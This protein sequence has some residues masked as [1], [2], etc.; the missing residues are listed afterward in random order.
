MWTAFADR[1]AEITEGK[2]EDQI[3]M[4]PGKPGEYPGVRHGFLS[5]FQVQPHVGLSGQPWAKYRGFQIS[6]VISINS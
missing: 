6:S 1:R 4:S 3:K 5:K 2:A